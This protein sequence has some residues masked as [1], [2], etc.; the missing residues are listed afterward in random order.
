MFGNT[1]FTHSII[2]IILVIIVLGFIYYCYKKN[3]QNYAEKMYN[4]LHSK[5]KNENLSYINFIKITNTRDPIIYF[6]LRQLYQNND[7]VTKENYISLFNKYL[8]TK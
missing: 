5:F 7:V 4:K 2:S 8:T 1:E 6:E 3:T